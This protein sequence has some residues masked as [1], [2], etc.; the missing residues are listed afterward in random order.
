MK[1]LHL[2]L[3]LTRRSYASRFSREEPLAHLY[4]APVLAPRHDQRLVDLRVA[5]DLEGELAGFRPAAAVVGVGPLTQGALGS[6][7]T[8]LRALVPG[9]RVL[10]VP[11]A[12]YGNSHVQ[13]R[14][15]DFVHPLADALA[16]NFFLTVLQRTVPAVLEAWE[17][18][19]ALDGIAGLLIPGGEGERWRQTQRVPNLVGEIGVPDRRILGRA[20]GRYRFAGIGRMAHLFYTYGCRYKCRFCPMSK[21][22]GSIVARP[23]DDV[24]RELAELNEPHVFLEDYEPFLAP[25]AMSALADAVERAGIRKSWYMLTRSD[26]ALR[27]EKLI[28]RWK[29]LGLRWLYLGLDAATPQRL[30]EIRKGNTVETNEKGLRRMLELGLCV[31]VGFVVSPAATLAD[32]AALRAYARHLQGALVTFTVETPLVGTT[33]FDD[34]ESRLT[35]RD[36]SLFDLGHAVLPTTLPLDLFYRRMAR[37]HLAA[38]ARTLPAMLRHFPLRDVLRSWAIGFPAVLGVLRSARDHAEPRDGLPRFAGAGRSA[39]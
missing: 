37:L 34:S 24:V 12:A 33:L 13:E 39:A 17:G 31:T 7:L 20:R 23:V 18:G 5:P 9:I 26:T 3:P 10:L 2:Q 11:E 38:G 4:L 19:R 22:D 1:V 8:R 29:D 30:K 27:E 16:P 14:P 25:E 28:R 35:T 6:A 36:W 32:F 15:L 21:H